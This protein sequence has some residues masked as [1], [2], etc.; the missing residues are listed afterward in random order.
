MNWK[1]LDHRHSVTIERLVTSEKV[2]H[3]LGERMQSASTSGKRK[4]EAFT[5]TSLFEL[6]WK[7]EQNVIQQMRGVFCQL[8]VL[9]QPLFGISISLDLQRYK[10]HIL[11]PG[12]RREDRFFVCSTFHR[13]CVAKLTGRAEA[14][15]SS[16]NKCMIEL[17]Y[18]PLPLPQ[19][20]YATQGSQWGWSAFCDLFTDQMINNCNSWA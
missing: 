14:C 16:H 6:V 11:Y 13:I 1:V 15:Q 4:K 20:P 9:L 18:N 12:I 7:N 5:E 19:E 8:H 17:N 2:L 3:A 10:T